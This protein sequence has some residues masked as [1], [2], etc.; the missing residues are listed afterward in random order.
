MFDRIINNKRNSLCVLFLL[1]LI[2]RVSLINMYNKDKIAPDGTGYYGLAH[3]L[4][5]G[6]GY[7]LNGE[8]YFLR[9]PGYPVFLSLA[10]HI[11]KLFG[12]ETGTLVFDE[13]FKILN[14][15]PEIVVAKYIEAILDSFACI[16]FFL[17]ISH[18]LKRKY[19]LLIAIAFCFYYPYAHHVTHILR[20]TLQSFLALAM[21]YALLQY[22]KFNSIKFLIFTGVFWGLLNHTFQA[23]IIFAVSIPIFIWI[24]KK[25]FKNAIIPSVIV[26]IV[27]LI[28]VS[29]W[30]I[31]TYH[32]YPDV[33]IL[34]S[35]GT[36]L[37]REYLVYYSS[38]DKAEYYGLISKGQMD[39]TARVDLVD[40]TD[41]EKFKL[42]F[43]G[44]ILKK[45]DSINA[46]INEPL[47][48]IRKIKKCSIYFYK[49]W[50]P[51]KILRIST[52]ELIMNRP[53]LAMLLIFPVLIISLF[54]FVGL[55]KYY[56]RFFK[57]NI[58]FTT[59]IAVFFLISS[60]YRRMLP[61]LPYIFLYGMTG[62]IYIYNRIFNR[63]N[64]EEIETKLFGKSFIT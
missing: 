7:I 8:K 40:L 1:A 35:F 39:S 44:T 51:T 31:R 45:A 52:K 58:V 21:C 42:S 32:N 28:T 38:L 15:V 56:P 12:Y 64:D 61:A 23:N 24:S 30:L 3:N 26:G 11:T 37:T 47:I 5:E 13:N 33:R 63:V 59:Y 19:A 43:D 54:A 62:M 9:E 25:S 60:E 20:E 17:L 49:A 34:K 10:F 2:M 36:S 18:I 4:S 16:L 55:V 53:L 27:M 41:N 14:N 29:P 57:I 48:S 50:F 46:L 6:N 22:F